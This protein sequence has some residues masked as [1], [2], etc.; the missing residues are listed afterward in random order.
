MYL[1][2]NMTEQ[3]L[4]FSGNPWEEYLTLDKEAE[5]GFPERVI[6]KVGSGE[7]ICELK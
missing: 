3:S 2:R 1:V 7:D 5:E 6:L 4:G